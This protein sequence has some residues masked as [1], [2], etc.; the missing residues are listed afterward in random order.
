MSSFVCKRT[1]DTN[2]YPYITTPFVH[3]KTK[4][5]LKMRPFPLSIISFS[6][7][8]VYFKVTS[9]PESYLLVYR[10]T[11][12]YYPHKLDR[13]HFL[14]RDFSTPYSSRLPTP[15]LPTIFSRN[16]RPYLHMYW[17]SSLT[18]FWSRLPKV[19]DSP[20]YHLYTSFS[21]SRENPGRCLRT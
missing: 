5:T 13:P 4:S 11:S 9:P 17:T 6:C 15:F 16:V 18:L 19:S 3:G 8:C 10:D 2:Y 1:C 21:Y 7:L 12:V 20:S 14:R